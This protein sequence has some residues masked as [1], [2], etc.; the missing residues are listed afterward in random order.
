MWAR[1][2]L[3]HL[4]LSVRSQQLPAVPCDSVEL[5]HTNAKPRQLCKACPA[6]SLGTQALENN[7]SLQSQWTMAPSIAP[8]NPTLPNNVSPLPPTTANTRSKGMTV[9]FP[10]HPGPK[11]GQATGSLVLA[12]RLWTR[13]CGHSRNW[14]RGTDT[15]HHTCPAISHSQGRSG[16]VEGHRGRPIRRLWLQQ[17]TCL[18]ASLPAIW[19]RR[20]IQAW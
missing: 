15:S 16:G 17:S 14:K 12:V 6:V 5:E 19:N 3:A 8:P 4:C 7:W 11:V 2:P 13:T 1:A 9:A 20:H 18:S 10:L